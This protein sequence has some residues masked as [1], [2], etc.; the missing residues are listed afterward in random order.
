MAV[1]VCMFIAL[2]VACVFMGWM[3]VVRVVFESVI[4]EPSSSRLP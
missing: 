1:A 4:P 3:M 2:L